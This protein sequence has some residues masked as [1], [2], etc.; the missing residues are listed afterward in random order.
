VIPLPVI[1]AEIIMALGGALLLANLWALLRPRFNPDAP[2]PA[3]RGRVL[4]NIGIGVVVLT[5][6][7]A[8]FITRLG[9]GN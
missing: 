7:F 2:A 4:I 6:G 9:Q 3:A 5:W 1:L 8:S